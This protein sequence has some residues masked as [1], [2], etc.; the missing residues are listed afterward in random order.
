MSRLKFVLRV[1]RVLLNEGDEIVQLALSVKL[2]NLFAVLVQIQSGESVDLVLVAQVLVDVV[3]GRAVDLG[4]DDAVDVGELI[5]QLFP[6]GR[7][8][9]AVAAPGSEELDK[10]HLGL[11]H[12]G[13]EF[14]G[15]EV[16]DGGCGFLLRN[17]IGAVVG[18]TC[19]FFAGRLDKV[20]EFGEISGAAISFDLLSV[21]EI[22]KS[23][24]A[25]HFIILA[26]GLS[27]RA[28]QLGDLDIGV[29]LVSLGQVVPGGREFLAVSAPGRVELDEVVA[30]LDVVGEGALSQN[31]QP[32]VDFGNFRL[33]N[34]FLQ[35]E[36]RLR[37][38]D[39]KQ[40]D[41]FFFLTKIMG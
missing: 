9:L 17:L 6:G 22:G 36:R 15:A 11:G 35:R 24:I 18:L 26:D 8:S 4:D 29:L 16:G 12:G 38:G 40:G 33:Q 37:K 27:G 7:E 1:L 23:R 14:A 34:S 31:V 13:V 5:A 10:G 3:V 32:V 41:F 19:G 39:K 25:L 2:F 30:L 21:A 28:V 20:L